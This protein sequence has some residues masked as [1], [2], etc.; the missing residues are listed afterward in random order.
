MIQKLPQEVINQIAAGEVIE[1]PSSVIKELVDN[2][3][4]A[5]ATKIDIKIK[6]GGVKYIEV[7]DNGS[8]IQPEEMHKA[9]EA[10][11][12]S[13]I[14]KLEDLNEVL[15]MG[16]R[17]EALSTI[18]SVSNI[19]MIS[20]TGDGDFAYKITGQG[21][22]LSEPAKTPREKGTTII[23]ENLFA[24]IPARLKYMRAE[25]T[26]Y[27]KVLE[28][29]IPFFLIYPNI[30][31]TFTN[32]G[33]VM[34]SLPS[35]PNTKPGDINNLRV[36]NV[37][38]SDFSKEMLPL[39]YSGDGV[40]ILGLIAKPQFNY[41]KTTHQYFFLNH[42][43]ILDRGVIK[44]VMEGYSRYIPHGQKVPFILSLNMEPSLVDV[45]VH[46]RKEEVRFMNPF[47]VYSAVE[48]SVQQALKDFRKILQ[49]F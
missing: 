28:I 19:Q 40:T 35:I 18:V 25:A 38:K 22:T 45:N 46:P 17:G 3:I 8:G 6:E 47:R 43:P 7:S 5:G 4:D 29:L 42:R 1:R 39:Y 16:F 10:H 9:F 11:A 44:A 27:R 12:T 41:A 37:L 23:V 26:E 36:E 31:F 32:N 13:K 49:Q 21:V 33:K 15:S 24:N 14:Q 30:N 20:K 34:Y 48:A 2:S